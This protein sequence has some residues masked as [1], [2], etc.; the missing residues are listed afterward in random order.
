[1][2]PHRII[3]LVSRIVPRRF[4]S[5]WQQEWQ[6]ELFYHQSRSTEHDA[7]RRS[8]GA[9]RDAL[10]M[11]PRRLED[12]MFQD[13]RY[14]CRMLAKSRG[15]TLIALLTLGIGIGAVTSMFSVIDAVVLRPL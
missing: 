12:E 11:Q 8:L 2:K 13:V 15:F 7:L 5:E 14:G 4:R 1:M 10:A 3:H 9:F 6:S